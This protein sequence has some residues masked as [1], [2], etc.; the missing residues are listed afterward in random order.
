MGGQPEFK[1]IP[2]SSYE[3]CIQKGLEFISDKVDTKLP[4][5]QGFACQEQNLPQ[6]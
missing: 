3:D 1:E 4:Y 5:S 6:L 2:V